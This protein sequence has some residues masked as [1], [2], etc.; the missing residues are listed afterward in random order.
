MRITK[1][2]IENSKLIK[3]IVEWGRQ[4]L[5]SHGYTLKSD[6]PETVQDTPWSFVVRYVTS[7]GYVYLKYTPKQLALEAAIIRLLRSPFRAAVPEVI[8]DNAQLQC[9]LM[10]DA[11]E[12]LRAVLKRQFDAALLAKAIDQFTSMQLTVADHVHRFLDIGV[13][14][15][16]L[17]QLAQLFR[18]LLGQEEVLIEDG[19]SK[20]E[21]ET[22]ILLLPKVDDL[23][24]RLSGYAIQQTLV[25]CDFHDNNILV[26]ALSRNITFID[27]GEIV[28]SHPFFSLIGCLQQVQYHHAL[29]DEQD[30]Y[31]QLIEIGF[32]HYRDVES[33]EGLA[34]AFAIAQVLW[35]LYEGLA[36]YRL[37][38]ACDPI[39]FKA[40]QRHGKLRDALQNFRS[41]CFAFD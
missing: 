16:R 4:S 17:H 2:L 14:D 29:R 5:L 31:R 27:L 25:Q 39:R 10:K 37:M 26:D 6:L 38:C 1:L 28:I 11:G 36:Q 34:E 12:P 3:A 40:F 15:W 13:P 33:T 24:Q 32:K 41:A 23:C 8:A 7:A 22:L 30:A 35:F 19:L 9:F 21:I 18:Q 20:I